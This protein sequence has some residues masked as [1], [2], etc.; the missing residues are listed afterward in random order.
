MDIEI[1]TDR[2]QLEPSKR[3]SEVMNKDNFTGQRNTEFE[4][5]ESISF[6][7]III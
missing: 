2:Q 6:P 3:I 1:Y 7:E 5:L 4:S